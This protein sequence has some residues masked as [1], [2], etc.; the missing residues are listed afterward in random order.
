MEYLSI[1]YS[2]PE[3]YC[4]RC[5]SARGLFPTSLL[6]S[7]QAYLLMQL[8]QYLKTIQKTLT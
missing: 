1:L 6:L 8:A 7:N 3:L 4:V 2:Q 5:K